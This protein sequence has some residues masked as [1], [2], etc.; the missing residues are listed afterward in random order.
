[1]PR[2]RGFIE[3]PRAGGR[4][5]PEPGISSMD[6]ATALRAVGSGFESRIPT[7]LSGKQVHLKV[8]R[9]A[10]LPVVGA[11]SSKP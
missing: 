7:N 4:T 9:A 6:R 5:L 11:A 2:W 1:M 8:N 10:L 3:V